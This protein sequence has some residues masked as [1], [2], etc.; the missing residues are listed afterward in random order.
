MP[1]AS[2]RLRGLGVPAGSHCVAPSKFLSL[3]GLQFPL[4]CG[5]GG[6]GGVWWE[7]GVPFALIFSEEVAVR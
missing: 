3:S 5:L 4:Q 6:F 7:M 1:N 2:L